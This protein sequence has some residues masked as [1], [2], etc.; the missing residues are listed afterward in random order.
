MV[1]FFYLAFSESFIS[2]HSDGLADSVP[3]RIMWTDNPDH[4]LRL[5][6]LGL[7]RRQ[8]SQPCRLWF[9]V[10]DFFPRTKERK[11]PEND[12]YCQSVLKMQKW[13]REFRRIIYSISNSYNSLYKYCLTF[14]KFKGEPP[15]FFLQRHNDKILILSQSHKEQSNIEIVRVVGCIG[16]LH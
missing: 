14:S 7:A 3:G 4:R 15:N 11:E 1:C 9:G 8:V 12:S 6:L 10:V 16:S 2:S 5:D 13:T